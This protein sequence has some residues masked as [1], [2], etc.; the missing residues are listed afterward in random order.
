ML[1]DVG[2]PARVAR[3]CPAAST[4]PGA[5]GGR[6]RRRPGGAR[7]SAARGRAGS[8]PGNGRPRSSA[9]CAGRTVGP[10]AAI[11]S[12]RNRLTVALPENDVRLVEEV[13]DP[14]ATAVLRTP[15]V[16]VRD[17]HWLPVSSSL[18]HE[19][20]AGHDHDLWMGAREPV[21]DAQ[22]VGVEH[23]VRVGEVDPLA[24]RVVQAQVAGG[25][26]AAVRLG[27]H[28]DPQP[29]RPGPGR[30]HVEGA[31]GGAVVDHDDLDPCGVEALALDRLDV[32]RQVRLHVVDRGDDRE[33][34]AFGCHVRHGRNRSTK[35][36]LARPSHASSRAAMNALQAA[37][38]TDARAIAAGRSSGRSTRSPTSSVRGSTYRPGSCS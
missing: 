14:V 24:G 6:R 32:L 8:G 17:A 37:S 2:E 12:M 7:R 34:R 15:R 23:V 25:P 10:S 30:E 29:R 36:S 33:P 27:E 4:F 19:R 38:S 22:E 28:L 1:E 16:A 9:G 20:L 31:I 5:R 3:G 13:D 26:L 18:E 35:R 21:G 11:R